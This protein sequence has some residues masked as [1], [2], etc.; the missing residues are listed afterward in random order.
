MHIKYFGCSMN[1]LN[2][3]STK[4]FLSQ[5]LWFQGKNQFIICSIFSLDF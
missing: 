3:T 4:L 2:N 5:G 1:V